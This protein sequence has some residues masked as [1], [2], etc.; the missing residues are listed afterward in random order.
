[1]INGYEIRENTV[2]P[3]SVFLFLLKADEEGRK[4]IENRLSAFCKLTNFKMKGFDY[5]FELSGITDDN[6]LNKFKNQVDSLASDIRGVT[7]TFANEHKTE[8]ITLDKGNTEKSRSNASANVLAEGNNIPTMP[9]LS[10]N[11]E[12]E[13]SSLHLAAAGLPVT[14]EREAT[15]F[16]GLTFN[17]KLQDGDMSD[18][19]L[20]GN[21]LH[22]EKTLPSV[23]QPMPSLEKEPPAMQSIEEEPSQS[24]MPRVEHEVMSDVEKENQPVV[25]FSDEEMKNVAI[26]IEKPR[27]KK[28]VFGGLFGKVKNMFGS[29]KE[30]AKQP[31]KTQQPQQEQKNVK[32][33]QPEPAKNKNLFNRQQ[34]VPAEQEIKQ[35]EIKPEVHERKEKRAAPVAEEDVKNPF[36]DLGSGIIVKKGLLTSDDEVEDKLQK[37]KEDLLTNPITA[38]V[39]VD[40]IFAAETVYNI[41]ADSEQPKVKNINY[42]H[43]QENAVKMNVLPAEKPAPKKEEHKEE[44]QIKPAPQPQKLKEINKAEESAF[45]K[46]TLEVKNIFDEKTESTQAEKPQPELKIKAK[47]SMPQMAEI[48]END[49]KKIDA[50]EKKEDKNLPVNMTELNS[51]FKEQTHKQETLPS[52]EELQN[53]IKQEEAAKEENKNTGSITMPVLAPSQNKT[54]KPETPSES[55]LDEFLG[56]PR[57]TKKPAAT[58]AQSPLEELIGK[59]TEK[60]AE[61]PQQKPAEKPAPQPQQK[62]AE[63]P[64][65]QPQQKPTEKPAEQ[66]AEQPA[67]KMAQIPQTP[68]E[69]K[70]QQ[71]QDLKKENKNM[72]EIK[73]DELN[74]QPGEAV[75]MRRDFTSKSEATKRTDNIDHTLHV[76][77]PAKGTKYRN[78][79]IEMP[80]IPTYTFANMDISPMRFAHAMAMSTLEGLGVANNPFLLQGVS[81]TGKTHFLHALGYEISKQIPQSKILFTNG[82]RFSRGIQYSL[83]KGQKDKLDAFF[84][85]MDVLIIDD[86]HLTAVNE[87]NREYI[88]K[89]LNNFLKQKKQMIFSSKYPPESLK[90]FEE[91]VNFKFALGTITELKVPNRTH[92]ARL[93]NKIVMGANLEL[94]EMQVNEFFCNR[95]SSLGEVS[96]DVKRI[97]VLSRRIES[98]GNNMVSCEN[99]LKMMTGINGENEESEIVKKNFEDI[100]VLTK[101]SDDKWGN[102]GFFF[103]ASQIDKFRWVAFASQEAAKELGI[104]G[105][106]NY[107]LKSAYSTEHIISAAFK[108]ANICDVKG[109]KGAVILGPSLTDVKEPIRDNFYDILTHM[110]EVMM[111]RCGTINFEN[112]KKPSAYIKM[113]GDILK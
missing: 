19:K 70:P 62:P 65:P 103:P 113:L 7:Q 75:G 72:Q 66:P 11:D 56:A 26:S 88:S 20:E 99:I 46:D 61:Q 105:G 5:V 111:I 29:S 73:K 39:E 93:V 51:V 31:A 106:F 30:K 44:P 14:T 107:A 57:E 92:F 4:K 18:I 97:K 54:A 69:Q 38:K 55:P 60:P 64:A 22:L 108:I 87:H 104:K 67:I 68:A 71:V 91:L 84:N 16:D 86:I 13:S 32:Q 36:Q 2:T 3:N 23:Y 33:A 74:K 48:K 41:Y 40:D 77:T 8:T 6:M 50:K 49:N 63:K 110:L 59:P 43:S 98:S 76:G 101:N 78:Y 12:K 96:R 25:A 90:R 109:L 58:P 45:I 35:E 1:M 112:I 27:Q 37:E 53:D 95:C 79:P 47:E 82:V 89:I 17:H 34:E 83:E 80:L 28:S 81:G 102:F 10:I 21:S 15:A 9:G 42:N 52:L 24:T 94:T 100:T 85:G